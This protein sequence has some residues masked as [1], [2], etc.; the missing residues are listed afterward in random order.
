[1][2]QLDY[3][4][5]G[6]RLLGNILAHYAQET[7]DAVFLAFGERRISYADVYRQAC[8]IAQGL[9]E[10]GLG[11]NDRL[12]IFMAS[13][14]EFVVVSFAAKFIG[15]QMIPGNTDYRGVWLADTIVDSD[16]AL[17]VTDA[18]YAQ[19]LQAV[20]TSLPVCVFGDCEASSDDW[21]SF[22]E[23]SRPATNFQAEDLVYGDTASIMWT[24]GTTGK[25][26]G[27]MQSHNA[28]IRS[29]LSANEMGKMTAS[30]V[31]YN[32]LPLYN[33][34]AWVTSVY[35]ALMIGATCAIDPA[36]SASTFWNRVRF[37]GATHVFTLGAMHMFLWAAPA[38]E[39][40]A[41]NVI[42]SAQ[43][44]P[45]PDDIREPFK[46][47]FGIPV[48]HQGF[49]QS[50]IMLLMRRIDDGVTQWPPNSLGAPAKDIEV[51][52]L[53]EQGQPVAV[54]EAGE[55]CIQEK[56]PHVL[57]NGYFN[58]EEAT[59]SAF[60]DGWYH[61]GDLLKQDAEGYYY[62]VDRKKDLIR[63]KG[64]SVSSVAIEAVA[65]NHPAVASAAAYGIE[66]EELS[67]EHEIMLAVIPQENTSIDPQALARF[68]N[69]N[70]PYFF[71][72]RYIECVESLPMTPT[73]KVQKNQLRERGL[74]A[75]T[76]DAKAA[77][78]V[79]ER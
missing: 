50:E 12:C 45:M 58:N 47:R 53:D 26:K 61:T 10:R 67:S 5:K 23:L 72:P 69:D 41:D 21:F 56:S 2:S 63:Y 16:P 54:G 24:S 7:P 59:R 37:Y 57:F 18:E 38:A 51:A 55:V 64:R 29:A 32:C 40:D 33:S 43:M 79:I 3:F 4:D 73:Q 78:F 36:F 13:S 71:V 66:S 25:S 60:K 70:A 28:W 74:T 8:E 19:R 17:I 49:G 27:V 46:K 42:R 6:N 34:A 15:A 11:K 48:I 39:N 68:I 75:N 44:V 22:D 77:G 31:S 76:W 65:R 14:P 30:D 1:M 62:F 52:L 35:P 9:R 20:A